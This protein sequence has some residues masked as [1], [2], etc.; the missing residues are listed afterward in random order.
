M[1][2]ADPELMRA[3][4]RF[5]VLDTIRRHGPIARVEICERT[6]LSATTVSAITASLID[7]GLVAPQHIGDLRNGG[8]GRPRVMLTLNPDAAC[9]VGVKISPYRMHL[10]VTDF[11]GD[12]LSELGLPVRLDREPLIVLSYLIEDGVRSCVTKAGLTIEAITSLS[13]ALPG[14]VEYGTGC[15][16]ASALIAEPDAQLAEAMVARLGIPT[17]VESDANAVAQAEYWFGEARALEDFV[18]VSLENSI[19]LAVMHEGQLFRGAL[20]LSPNL[21]DLI[22]SGPDRAAPVRLATIAEQEAIIAGSEDV[23]SLRESARSGEAAQ[24]IVKRIEGGDEGLILSATRAGKSL[25]LALANIVTMLAPPRI[26]LVG[27]SLALGDHLLND[28]IATLADA[29]PEPLAGVS[30]IVVSMPGDAAWARGA[31]ALALRE[32][33]GAPWSTTGPARHAYKNGIQGEN[34][35]R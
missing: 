28:L 33:Y 2:T 22:V 6:E 29:T 27:S 17:I 20:G 34:H 31:A 13:V 25:G 19:G 8:R 15:V 35:G 26:F 10:V 1:K 32:L 11:Q 4:N 9:I 30:E 7:D 21:G 16:R 5:H 14:V 23:E 3:I 24:E 18:L 12:V